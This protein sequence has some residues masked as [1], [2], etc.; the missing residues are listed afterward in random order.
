MEELQQQNAAQAMLYAQIY[1]KVD[2]PKADAAVNTILT[3]PIA[4]GS[5]E[6]HVAMDFSFKGPMKCLFLCLL[7]RLA[8]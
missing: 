2:N 4:R 6:N 7:L 8:K 3:M 1:Q 5:S